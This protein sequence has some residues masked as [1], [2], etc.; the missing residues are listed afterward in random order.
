MVWV[1]GDGL[2]GSCMLRNMRWFVIVMCVLVNVV[3]IFGWMVLF[4][5]GIE[6]RFVRIVLM[7]VIVLFNEFLILDIVLVF[8]LYMF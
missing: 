1:R 2:G 4:L 5:V 3:R 7:V 8:F 6:L